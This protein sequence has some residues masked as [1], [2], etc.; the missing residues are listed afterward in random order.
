MMCDLSRVESAGACAP[1][2]SS[3]RQRFCWMVAGGEQ[4]A[5][6]GAFGHHLRDGATLVVGD[7]GVGCRPFEDDGRGG[8]VGRYDGDPAHGALSD[9]GADLEAERVAIERQGRLRVVVRQEAGITVD[10]HAVRLGGARRLRFSIPRSGDLLFDARRQSR[11]RVG[12]AAPIG[13]TRHTHQL[14]EAGAER[15]ERCAADREADLG[16]AHVAAP[17]QRHR[18]LDAPRHVVRVRRL[19][20]RRRPETRG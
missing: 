12:S 18:A 1:A 17:E 3:E 2:K 7:A 4:H 9:V 14:G 5:G 20:R 10:V 15:A 13:A 19:T 6:V 11:R 8:L 16:G